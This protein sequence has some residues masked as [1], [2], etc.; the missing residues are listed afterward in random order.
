MNGGIWM[1]YC[2]LRMS[3]SAALSYI[4]NTDFFGGVM[5]FVDKKF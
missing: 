2:I 5:S 4:N 1:I 3:L